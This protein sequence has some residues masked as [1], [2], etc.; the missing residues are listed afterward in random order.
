MNPCRVENLNASLEEEAATITPEAHA[1]IVLEVNANLD[2]FLE[3]PQRAEL[4]WDG[5][6]RIKAHDFPAMLKSV[7]KSAGLPFRNW[8]DDPAIYAYRLTN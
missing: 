2:A 8:S 3:W 4:L 1:R 7:V 5:C 6:Y